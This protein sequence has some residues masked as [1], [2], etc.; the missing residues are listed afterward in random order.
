MNGN[1]AETGT[2]QPDGRPQVHRVHVALEKSLQGEII[3]TGDDFIDSKQLRAPFH[4]PM[5]PNTS[6]STP[7]SLPASGDNDDRRDGRDSESLA[8]EASVLCNSSARGAV[9]S[10]LSS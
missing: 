9:V 1:Q 6:T 7:T 3:E 2:A 10:G 8:E 4:G 5:S